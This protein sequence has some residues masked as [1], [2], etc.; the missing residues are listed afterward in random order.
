MSVKVKTVNIHAFRGIPDLQLEL[1]G[2]S[3]LVQG[4][5]GSGKSSIIDAVEFF[6]RG[7]LSY[8]EGEGT[9]SLSLRKHVP[10]KN[11]KD[12]DVKIE[13]IFNPG[14]IALLRTFKDAPSP[15][16]PFKEYF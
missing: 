7:T 13:M 9:Q 16:E 3:L 4:E 5:N 15:P 8:F 1:N 11:F 2:K 6:F 10:H 12:A 14:G